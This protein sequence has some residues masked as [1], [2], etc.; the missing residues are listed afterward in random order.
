MDPIEFITTENVE[1][2]WE[3]IEDMN[4]QQINLQGLREK[5]IQ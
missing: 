2:L 1:M 5:F 4:N 3:I